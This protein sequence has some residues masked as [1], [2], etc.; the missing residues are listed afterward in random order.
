MND[1]KKDLE[2]IFQGNI[3]EWNSNQTMSHRPVYSFHGG[4]NIQEYMGSSC[5]FTLIFAV[6]KECNPIQAFDGITNS[7]RITEVQTHYSEHSNRYT[8]TFVVNDLD[9]FRSDIKDFTW[10]KYNKEFTEQLD[11][12]LITE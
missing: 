10:K 12:K 6:L 8:V 3:I 7:A 2:S 1:M 11:K 4:V 9:E 5:Q